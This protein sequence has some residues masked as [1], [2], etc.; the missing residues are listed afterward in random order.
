[1]YMYKILQTNEYMSKN[2]FVDFTLGIIYYILLT[3]VLPF[4]SWRVKVID[5][6]MS[7]VKL[8]FLYN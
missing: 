6:Y 5:I 3:N 8:N 1:M 7:S 4:Y 2:I